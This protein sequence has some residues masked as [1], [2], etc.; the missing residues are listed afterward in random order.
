MFT[1]K[2][3]F[4]EAYVPRH[5]PGRS[6]QLGALSDALD[7]EE[8]D[9]PANCW[10]FGPSGVG[11]TSTAQHLL[12]DLRYSHAVTFTHVECVGSSRWEL[13]SAVAATHPR[14]P[15]HDGMGVE[16]LLDVLEENVDSPHVVILDEFDGLEA[17]A[18][19]TDLADIDE[20]SFICIAHDRDDA[21]DL[22]PD[23]VDHL[24]HATAIEYDPYPMDAMRGILEARVD[25]GLEP[26]IITT[27]QLERIADEAAGSARYGVQALRSAA[28][29]GL[30]RGHTEIR[31]EDID[32]CFD[33]ATG[34]IREEL[35]ASLSRQH[36]IVYGIIRDAGPDGIRPQDILEQYRE[37]SESPRSRQMVVRY[38]K[39]L[40]RYGL[41]DCEGDGSSGWDRWWAVD[42][43]LKAPLRAE[44]TA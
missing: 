31:E 41:V 5:F 40:R 8:P 13:L 23:A 32:D 25:T 28:E 29:L 10:E 39:K 27:N 12:Q 2:D 4:T 20:I 37:R 33:H 26:G 38:R 18:A 14:V 24:E 9:R 22:L 21:F 30:E 44:S 42:D 36:H 1:R 34:R 15:Q 35:L 16:H 7:P 3:V 19:L 43:Q 6:S 17:P 11:K